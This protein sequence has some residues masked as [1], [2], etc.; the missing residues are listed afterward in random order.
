MLGLARRGLRKEHLW[1]VRPCPRRP[2]GRPD[3]PGCWGGW[4]FLSQVNSPRPG[5][6]R[7]TS[8]CYDCWRWQILGFPGLHLGRKPIPYL[9]RT[10]RVDRSCRVGR[11]S[12]G[13]FLSRSGWI[14]SPWTRLAELGDSFQGM[15]AVLIKWEAEQ[16]GTELPWTSVSSSA[17]TLEG[18]CS[19]A[20][21]QHTRENVQQGAG[22][23]LSAF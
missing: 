18:C 9:G 7:V 12:Y 5:W 23:A 10:L 22:S 14:Y 19:E 21:T 2:E 6:L 20:L 16:S 17:E 3:I 8:C 15:P 1:G 13:K 11:E 4:R